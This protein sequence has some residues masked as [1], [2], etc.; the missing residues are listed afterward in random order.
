VHALHVTLCA[1]V[2]IG[3]QPLRDPSALSVASIEDFLARLG[4]AVRA[5]RVAAAAARV[6]RPLLGGERG[7]CMCRGV[8]QP[9]AVQEALASLKTAVTVKKWRDHAAMKKVRTWR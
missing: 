2:C 8:A 1:R 7:A 5:P 9:G 3:G 6:A 4:E